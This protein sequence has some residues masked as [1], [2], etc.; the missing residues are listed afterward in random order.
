M[1]EDDQKQKQTNQVKKNQS[2]Y[3]TTNWK[4]LIAKP[5]AV[6]HPLHLGR[7]VPA[8]RLEPMTVVVVQRDGLEIHL[9]H[10]LLVTAKHRVE[11]LSNHQTAVA[12]YEVSTV[13]GKRKTTR[14]W[15][16]QV[17]AI[18]IHP[19]IDRVKIVTNID[20]RKNITK[21]Q[22]QVV[23]MAV[24]NHRARKVM[25]LMVLQCTK[26]HLRNMDTDQVNT[27]LQVAAATQV[28]V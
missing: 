6:C 28:S 16:L 20:R 12:I 14:P 22:V 2:P 11:V 3:Q 23:R 17:E 4:I 13:G 15:D 10:R 19:K 26:A 1:V 8:P 27:T 25:A 18:L 5:L 9:C 24:P 21:V 7:A